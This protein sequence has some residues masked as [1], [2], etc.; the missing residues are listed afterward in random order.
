M[1]DASNPGQICQSRM[2][3]MP[4]PCRPRFPAA[5]PTCSAE[6][7]PALL[8]AAGGGAWP[9]S[10]WRWSIPHTERG[11]K[12]PSAEVPVPLAPCSAL[13]SGS[14]IALQRPSKVPTF[15]LTKQ[16]GLSGISSLGAWLCAF[17]GTCGFPRTEAPSLCLPFSGGR[18]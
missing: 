13:F 11:W 3:K 18:S 17:M 10:W 16:I 7:C 1:K 4:G 15:P 9:R 6:P 5:F 8:R 12:T 14:R 2:G